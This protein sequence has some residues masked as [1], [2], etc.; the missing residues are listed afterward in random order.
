MK[1]FLI[2][3]LPLFL[4]G[5]FQTT[6]FK[7]A[8]ES[9]VPS[10]EVLI[11]QPAGFAQ[12]DQLDT[13][14]NKADGSGDAL[15]QPKPPKTQIQEFLQ[16]NAD[17]KA[18]LANCYVE[19]A[20]GA[21][22]MNKMAVDPVALPLVTTLAKLGF[23]LIMDA[24]AKSLDD[25][26]ERSKQ[27]YGTTE[28]LQSQNLRTWSCI[29]VARITKDHSD[30]GDEHLGMIALFEIVHFDAQGKEY[31]GGASRILNNVIGMRLRP[32][33]VSAF[34]AVAVSKKGEADAPEV[35]SLSFAL[36]LKGIEHEDGKLPK[37][38]AFGAGT[39]SVPKVKIGQ[40][41]GATKICNDNDCGT[42]GL[43]PFP[44]TPGPLELT[45]AVTESGNV[46][47]NIDLAKAQ[48]A[49]FKAAMGPALSSAVQTYLNED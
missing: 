45:F 2:V 29:G 28:F 34:D 19:P 48:L 10:G 36:A 47:F 11:W 46:G 37:V 4:S 7:K 18:R 41:N 9:G 1:N 5:C 20:E 43:I 24:Q 22:D 14:R 44:A 6:F 32:L 40:T 12:K 33:F 27:T 13:F 31:A 8:N 35:I 26:K 15:A 16:V 25:L 42:T 17:A 21:G 30:N 49:A 3:V 23:D 38:V 39:L